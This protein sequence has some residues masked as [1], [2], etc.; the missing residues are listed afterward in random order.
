MYALFPGIDT[1]PFGNQRTP[2]DT[3]VVDQGWSATPEPTIAEASG[4]TEPCRR[5]RSSLR[6]RS[7]A[8]RPVA[9]AVTAAIAVGAGAGLTR[10]WFTGA[11]RLAHRVAPPRVSAGSSDRAAVAA[12]A[13][14]RTR[15]KGLGHARRG[16]ANAVK[17]ARHP[18]VSRT[19]HGAAG[20]TSHTAGSVAPSTAS[21][22]SQSPR[23]PSPAASPASEAPA[24]AVSAAP[25]PTPAQSS[26]PTP[27][28]ESGTLGPGSSPDS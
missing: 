17:R 18:A 19:P 9:V 6:L 21:T 15:N 2:G 20:S 5:A 24:T 7:I 27:F 4:A 8:L 14:P 11:T 23:A 3:L 25:R 28:G 12:T 10:S 22:G 13:G 16:R 1:T 26:R